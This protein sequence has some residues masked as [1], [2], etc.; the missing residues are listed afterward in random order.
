MTG[1]IGGEHRR[2]V[3]YRAS[4]SSSIIIFITRSNRHETYGVW[5][6]NIARNVDDNGGIVTTN[7]SRNGISDKQTWRLA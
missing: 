5:R 3:F 2:N 7:E 4:L 1:I 6:R